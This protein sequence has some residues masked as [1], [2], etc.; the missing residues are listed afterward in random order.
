MLNG[1]NAPDLTLQ[2]LDKRLI[3]YVTNRRT[4]DAGNNFQEKYVEFDPNIPNPD[5][6]TAA[7]RNDSLYRF[8]GYQIY[9]LKDATVSAADI[10]D[11][12]KARLVAQCDIENYVTKLVNWEFDQNLGGNVGSVKVDG[13]NKGIR[14]SFEITEDKFATGDLRLINNKQYYYVAVAY[15]YNEFK[16]YNQNDPTALDGQKKPYLRGRTNIKVY[17][18]IP[19]IPLGDQMNSD[20]GQGPTITRIQGQGNGRWFLNF[21][22]RVSPRSCQSLL[23]AQQIPMVIPITRSPT[24]PATRRVMV[25]SILRS[26]IR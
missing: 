2:E 16:K 23:Q 4:N 13:E 17:T 22:R 20:Y 19:H 12:N 18:A 1:P 11:P 21:Q 5:T 26:L 6:L 24:K 9:Q 10:D 25:R 8:E 3:L 15:A 7:E 14:H